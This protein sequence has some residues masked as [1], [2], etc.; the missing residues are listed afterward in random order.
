MRHPP[1]I[2]DEELRLRALAEYGFLDEPAEPGLSDVTQLAARMFG[3]P[4]AVVNLIDRNHVFFAASVG[5]DH[6]DPSL[7]GRDISFCAHAITEDSVMVVPDAT[8]DPRFHDNPLVT[9]PASFRFYAGVPLRVASGQALGAFCIIDTRA[10][11]SFSEFDRQQLESLA[12]LV[13]DKLELRRLDIAGRVSQERFRNIAATSPDSIICTDAEGS[14]TMWNAAAE[15]MFGYAAGEAVGQKIDL[16]IPD[17]LRDEIYEDRLRV[18][19]G[20]SSRLVGRTNDMLGLRKDGS[21]FPGELSLSMWRED[22]DLSFGAIIRDVT[23]RRR[24]EDRLYHLAHH[25]Q[26]TDLP[27]RGVLKQRVGE[28]IAG[29]Q[30][31]TLIIADLD[32]FKD[33][34]DTLGHDCGDAVLKEAARRLSGC[35]RP[36]DTV[37]RV[38][39]DEFALLLP[40]LADPMQAAAIAETAIKALTRPFVLDSHEIHMSAGAGIA[41]HPAHGES[42]DELIGNADLALFQAKLDGRGTRTLFTRAMRSAAVARRTYDVEIRRAVENGELRLYYQPQVRLSDGVLVGAE[43]LIRWLH[44][45]RGLVSPAAFLPALEGGLLAATVGDWVLETACTQAA[46]WR[47]RGA[48][49]FR[50]GVNLFGAQF[51]ADDLVAKVAAVLRDRHLSPDALELEITENIVLDQNDTVLGPLRALRDMGVGIAFDDYG[52]GYA[53]LSLLKRFPITRLKIDQTFVRTM[54]ESPA[55]DAIIRAVLYLGES[56]GLDVIAEGIETEAQRAQLIKNGCTEGQGYLFGRPMAPEDFAA[57]F[58]LFKRQTR[59][60]A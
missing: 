28:E 59:T 6:I 29:G 48:P 50:M 60:A 24:N 23:E 15:R 9:G 31:V 57:A 22:G 52:T 44:P 37:A 40:G 54:C 55:D 34:N 26:L 2:A 46:A 41:I 10:R 49:A 39:S 5:T 42:A 14:I 17:H 20:G 43:A 56:F 1:L 25:D 45:E 7:A 30:P 36:T 12:K 21:L 32:G 53:S 47:S 33:I 27:N 18:T 3:V 19:A 13:I 51:R 8:L 35:V 11:S 16:I 38:G 58:D 4:T